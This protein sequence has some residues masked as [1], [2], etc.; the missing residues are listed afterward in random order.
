[1]AGRAIL[2]SD[3]A[4][5]Q[6]LITSTAAI[7]RDVETGLF[8]HGCRVTLGSGEVTYNGVKW[9]R[10]NAWI[11][12]AA[13]EIVRVTGKPLTLLN[14]SLHTVRKFQRES[15]AFGNI[16]DVA[17][18]PDETSLTSAYIYAVAIHAEAYKYTRFIGS[19]QKAWKWLNSRSFHFDGRLLLL[20]STAGGTNLGKHSRSYD[21]NVGSHQGPGIGLAVWA[22]EGLCRINW[23]DARNPIRYGGSR[24]DSSRRVSMSSSSFLS[25]C[26]AIFAILVLLWFL[27]KSLDLPACRG[28]SC[29]KE[30]L[31]SP[32][33]TREPLPQ[34]IDRLP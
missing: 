34:D 10:A 32:S 26:Q 4:G 22:N 31:G 29:S 5:A 18:S 15:G 17:S 21:S 1:M 33:N 25:S 23:F 16:V 20:D 19:A 3:P 14:E 13:A 24:F 8:W 9:G 28:R 7:L 27:L 11:L 12:L 6:D 30:I 2:Q